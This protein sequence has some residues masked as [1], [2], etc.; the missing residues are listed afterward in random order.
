MLWSYHSEDVNTSHDLLMASLNQAQGSQQLQD[1]GHGS[2][3]KHIQQLQVWST[4]I[5]V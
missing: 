4:I 5:R 1:G 3:D 2:E